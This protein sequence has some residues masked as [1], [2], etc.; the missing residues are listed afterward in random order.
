MNKFVIKVPRVI[1]EARKNLTV[2]EF[3]DL[4]VKIFVYLKFDCKTDYKELYLTQGTK[5]VGN[6]SVTK[7]Y[8]M[9]I[10]VFKVSKQKNRFRD[11]TTNILLNACKS[12][13]NGHEQSL[14]LGLLV[15]FK[16]QY[17][18]NKHTKETVN[19]WLRYLVK[20]HYLS[21]RGVIRKLSN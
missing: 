11:K 2:N 6:T 15:T 9:I 7:Y 3:V 14:M 4:F 12:L 17:R 5:N 19:S 1:N 13:K 10:W 18:F 16:Y 8:N 21:E 20:N